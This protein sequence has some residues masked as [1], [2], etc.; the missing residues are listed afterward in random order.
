MYLETL[1]NF[2]VINYAE[3][4]NVHPNNIERTSNIYFLTHYCTIYSLEIMLFITWVRY[5]IFH[6]AFLAFNLGCASN[7]RNIIAYA[8]INSNGK[9]CVRFKVSV[10]L[11]WNACGELLHAEWRKNMFLFG[12]IEIRPGA[13]SKKG[14]WWWFLLNGIT[15][16]KIFR[17][18]I[19]WRMFWFCKI[20]SYFVRD[21]NEIFEWSLPRK[22]QERM[23]LKCFD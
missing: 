4:S 8:T 11:L 15:F 14:N 23:L 5:G 12:F 13:T 19:K 3:H 7:E 1:I 21:F 2:C 10:N 17:N 16:A 22:F 20:E 18:F 6:V 9:R